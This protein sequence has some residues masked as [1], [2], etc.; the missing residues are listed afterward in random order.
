[1]SEVG[2][3]TRS[4]DPDNAE[5]RGAQRVLLLG[6]L[7]MFVVALDTTIVNIAFTT[8]AG[9]LHT[10]T[11]RLAWVLNAYSLVFAALLI[12]AGWVA[13][14]YGR[15]RVFLTGLVGFAVMSALCAAAPNVGVLIAG[16][17]LQAVFAALVVPSS[18]ALILQEFPPAKRPM[19]VGTWGSMGAVAAALAPTTGAL[20]TEYASWRWIFLINVPIAAGM[21]VFG[22]RV[23]RETRAPAASRSRVP[24][25]VGTVLVAAIPALLSLALL[26]GPYW[27]WSDP[28]VIGG[29][30]LGF[31]LLPVFLWRSAAT[32]NPVMDLAL[33]KERRFLLVNVGT[34]LFATAFFGLLLSG[35]VFLQTEWHYSAL[36]SALATAPGP[37]VVILLAR[38]AGRL[39]GRLGHR[40]VLFAGAVAWCVGSGLF[41][42]Q[43]GGYAHWAADWLP[44]TVF[45]GIG[46]ALTL[47]IQPG[48][49]ARS[50]PPPRFAVGS[51]INA[52][53]RQ[54]GA[55]L[56]VSI[57]VAVQSSAGP[58]AYVDA[59]H[60]VWWA[61]AALGLAAGLVV[62]L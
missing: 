24:D 37:L 48:A 3:T 47:P 17:G 34:L 42:V 43:A 58:A 14:R 18:L 57:F 8:I 2:S 21:A 45:I 6:S 1:M 31:V 55:V 60:H 22:A 59:F 49:A 28:R 25:P 54:L 11:G 12:P 35:V 26:Q 40:R 19:A 51:A 29:F 52:S 16:R 15:K 38:P 44:G 20:L 32:A 56:G 27:G 50:L 46:A 41:A 33:F 61:F 7:G 39:A 13:D 30:V 5:R 23:L 62:C 53:F 4:A 10:S 36:R 9:S